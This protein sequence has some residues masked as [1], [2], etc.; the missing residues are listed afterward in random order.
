MKVL[1][2][3]LAAATVSFAQFFNF[4]PWITIPD[5]PD[6]NND[7]PNNND[8]PDNNSNPDNPFNKNGDP[9]FPQPGDCSNF[10]LPRTLYCSPD[11][12]KYAKTLLVTRLG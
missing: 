4:I 7:D 8:N 3:L 12:S 5:V 9:I 11:V 6:Q 1:L 2:L 10:E